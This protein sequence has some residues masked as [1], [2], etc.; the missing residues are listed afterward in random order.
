MYL[1]DFEELDK[2]YEDLRKYYN[3]K[4]KR[5]LVDLLINLIENLN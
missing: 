2:I 3:K 5:E 1:E 4:T